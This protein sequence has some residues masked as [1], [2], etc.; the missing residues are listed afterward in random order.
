MNYDIIEVTVIRRKAMS[1][2]D[3]YSPEFLKKFGEYEQSVS[4]IPL[5]TSQEIDV[6]AIARACDIDVKFDVVGHSGLSFN[7]EEES[8]RREIIVNQFEPEF[9]QRFTIAHEIGHIILGH[10][11]KSYRT[12]DMTKYKSTI[13]RMNEVAANNFAADLIMPRKLVIDV[14]TNSITKLG[15]SIDQSF[16]EYDISEIVKLAA[17]TLNV[18]RQALNYR[19][20]NLQVFIDE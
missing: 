8:Q 17:T 15:Y 18:S 1:Y 11:G 16:D 5:G 20:E 2:K 10:K 7:N 12:A 6:N 13:D 3:I 14:L 9:R 4:N 19:L